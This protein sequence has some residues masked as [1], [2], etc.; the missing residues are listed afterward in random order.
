M[1]LLRIPPGA[2][3]TSG[4][5]LPLVQLSPLYTYD[6]ARWQCERDG[7]NMGTQDGLIGSEAFIGAKNMGCVEL[8]YY[9]SGPADIDHH[10]NGTK[11]PPAIL[12]KGKEHILQEWAQAQSFSH[13]LELMAAGF[14][15][16]LCS[17]IPSGMMQTDAKGFFRMAGNIVGGHCYSFYDYD[18]TT[19]RATIGQAWERWGEKT[20]DPHYQEMHGFTQLGTCPLDELEKWFAPNKMASGSSEIMV[21][22]M[23]EG[24]APLIVD[25]SSM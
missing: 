20:S 8:E 16:A 18:K 21:A 2:T 15:I 5:P 1:T 17:E 22:N 14:P 12:E 23:I 11:P 25:Y 19:N 4:D 9:P 3:A 13:G 7:Y 24:F 10:V 6:V